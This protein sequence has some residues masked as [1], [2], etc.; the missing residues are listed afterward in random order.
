MMNNEVAYFVASMLSAAANNTTKY[1]WCNGQELDD[2]IA[3]ECEKPAETAMGTP[4]QD[5]VSAAQDLISNLRVA[6]KDELR[7]ELFVELERLVAARGVVALP[8]PVPAHKPA[9]GELKPFTIGVNTGG[10]NIAPTVP[11]V[12]TVSNIDIL[13]NNPLFARVT[14]NIERSRKGEASYTVDEL[15]AARG[16][17]F[18]AANVESFRKRASLSKF[19]LESSDSGEDSK[20]DKLL[21]DRLGYQ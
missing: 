21:A 15:V 1:S 5:A 17:R 10:M 3:E 18:D 11:T 8:P 14:K 2:I 19:E 4:M 6:I 20:W 9:P 12:G 13:A 7:M 16:D